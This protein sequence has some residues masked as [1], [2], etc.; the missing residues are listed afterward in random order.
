MLILADASTFNKVPFFPLDLTSKIGPI[1]LPP[2]VD[3]VTGQARGCACERAC[4]KL[5][6]MWTRKYSF[7][8]LTL[9]YLATAVTRSS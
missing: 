3:R 1:Q 2:A 5:E 9:I 8:D 4:P 6:C 7:P